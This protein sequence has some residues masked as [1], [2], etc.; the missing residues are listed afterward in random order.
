[1]FTL[2]GH[3]WFTSA[4]M[5]DGFLTL[6]QT[7]DNELSCFLV[8][9]GYQMVHG[10]R[11]SNHAIKDKLGDKSNASSE[12][13]Y[14]NAVGFMVGKPGRVHTILEMVVHTLDC[15]IA[16]AGLMRHAAHQAFIIQANVKHLVDI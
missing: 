11:F 2:V 12:V 7:G 5:S 8:H 6:A 13:E 10:M 1:M 16:S 9:D 14:R 15:T 3:K 4:P